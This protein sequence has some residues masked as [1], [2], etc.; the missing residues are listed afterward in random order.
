MLQTGGQV[1]IRI[2]YS[3]LKKLWNNVKILVCVDFSPHCILSR[4]K[5]LKWLSNHY[6]QDFFYHLPVP[7][8]FK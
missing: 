3:D 5:T 2:I 6:E 1:L 7:V 4:V 8:I